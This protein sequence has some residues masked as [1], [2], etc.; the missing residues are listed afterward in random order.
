ME[1]KEVNE[2]SRHFTQGLEVWLFWAVAFLE[3]ACGSEGRDE[4]LRKSV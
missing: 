2:Q 3:L 1:Q 4:S